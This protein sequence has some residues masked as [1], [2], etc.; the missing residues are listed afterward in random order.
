MSHFIL[1]CYINTAIRKY[2][3]L[4]LV[5]NQKGNVHNKNPKI[6]NFKLKVVNDKI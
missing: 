6:E 2:D 4:Y 3:V 5:E 1:D